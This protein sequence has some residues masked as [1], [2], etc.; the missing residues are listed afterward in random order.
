MSRWCWLLV[1][2]AVIALGSVQPSAA[3]VPMT[4][5]QLLK[6]STQGVDPSVL[7]SLVTRDCVDFDV[8]ADN[9]AELSKL[10]PKEV[11]KAALDCRSHA[12]MSVSPAP[13]IASAPKP[14]DSQEFGP[15]IVVCKPAG[16]G[17]LTPDHGAKNTC[18]GTLT[19]DNAG[20]SFATASCRRHLGQDDFDIAWSSLARICIHAGPRTYSVEFDNKQGAQHRLKLDPAVPWADQTWSDSYDKRKTD[21]RTEI[22]RLLD[23]IREHKP[24]VEIQNQCP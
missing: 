16:E 12:A 22:T 11:V 4:K 2:F 15:P 17:D 8:N 14:G 9:V 19:V 3:A 18:Y 23:R 13:T 5:D 20:V 7:A 21:C 1:G 10:L 6:L 24:Q